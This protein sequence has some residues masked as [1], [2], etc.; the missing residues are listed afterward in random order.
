MKTLKEQIENAKRTALNAFQNANT[1]DLLEQARIEYLGR[2]GILAELMGN[3]KN[4]SLEEKREIG[5]LL[6]QLKNELQALYETKIVQL[7]TQTNTI[8]F[9]VTTYKPHQIYGSLHILTQVHEQLNRIFTSMGYTIA[10][11]PEAETEYYNF[12]TLNIEKDHPARDAHD[13]FWLDPERLL[14]THTSPIQTRIMEHTQ[15]PLAIFAPGRVYRNEAIDASHDFMFNQA[16]C[17]FI[18]TDVSVAN[19]LA[20]AKTFLQAFFEKKDLNIRVRPGYFPF[21]EPGL[22][23]DGSCPFCT[24]GCSICKHTG[25]IELL[26]SGLVHPNVLNYCNINP[27]KYSGFAFG[28]GIERLAM[29]KYGINDVRLFHSTN[30]QF[31]NQ[32]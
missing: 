14:R 20:T 15:P 18:D 32:F 17:L 28:F 16:E 22:E 9:D 19:L 3:L 2:K 1:S 4:A 23:I 24:K 27:K 13:T 8:S 25:W 5:P 30:I 21:V 6:N 10:D 11:G 26:G 29:I 12:T 31:L 7:G